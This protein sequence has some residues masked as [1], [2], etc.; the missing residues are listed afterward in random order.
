M[1]NKQK[2][3]VKKADVTLGLKNIEKEMGAYNPCICRKTCKF[4]NHRQNF[5]VGGAKT[6]FVHNVMAI[7]TL[8]QI[9]EEN[10]YATHNEQDTLSR[11][12]GWGDMPQAFNPDNSQW[13]E[14][15]AELKCILTDSEYESARASTLNAHY[16]SNGERYLDGNQENAEYN[17]G[18]QNQVSVNR[19]A[20]SGGI[21]GVFT[22]ISAIKRRPIRLSGRKFSRKSDSKQAQKEKAIETEN[23]SHFYWEDEYDDELEI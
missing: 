20:G 6:K 14:E 19:N 21:I 22:H 1:K 5:A 13:A 4:Q 11:Y 17:R 23:S 12:V 18:N 9:E 15:Y 16:T 7:L 8:K 2:G 3:R 10:R